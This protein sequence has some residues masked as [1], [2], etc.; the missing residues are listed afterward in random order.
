MQTEFSVKGYWWLP[1]EPEKKLQ[2]TLKYQPNQKIYLETLGFFGDFTSFNEPKQFEIIHGIDL[3][4]KPITLVNC[5]QIGISMRFPGYQEGKYFTHMFLI[6]EHFPSLEKIHFKE[7]YASLAYLDEWINIY[8]FKIGISPENIREF[9]I[10]YHLP[11][12]IIAKINESCS[13]SIYFA[14]DFTIPLIVKKELHPKQKAL[15]RVKYSESRDYKEFLKIIHLFQD[16]L[17]F[18]TGERS[19]PLEVYGITRE[20]GDKIDFFYNPV[21]RI[22]TPK[23][24]MPH[25]M[26]FTFIEISDS[27]EERLKNWFDRAG[28]LRP[29]YI[30][31]FTTRYHSFLY[32]ENRFL[33][34]IQAIETYHSRICDKK[35]IPSE[36]CN[37]V[38]DKLIEAIPNYSIPEYSDFK[39]S[40]IARLNFIN[41]YSLRKRLKS[42]LSDVNEVF[43]FFIENPNEFIDKVVDTRNYLT[44][45]SMSAES[46][47]VRGKD[48]FYLTEKVKILVEI[49]LMRELGF[50]CDEINGII[51]RNRNFSYYFVTRIE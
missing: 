16:F 34:L 19:F 40:L 49:I 47:A 38:R 33:N 29:V 30:L 51:H 20:D 15:F 43:H 8:G 13:V 41:E 6:G 5:L 23:E 4:N 36:I 1:S 39:T 32:T 37:A 21:S 28:I 44:H 35:Y 31:Y 27:F 42:L 25:E 2:G 26:I 11:Q 12:E 48:L 14:C 3:N 45:Y 18:A 10:E 7:I 50:S 46:S 9:S 22:D 17:T 24:V